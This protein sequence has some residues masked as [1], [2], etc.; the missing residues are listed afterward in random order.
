MIAEPVTGDPSAWSRGSPFD[1]PQSAT[2]TLDLGPGRWRLS[3]Q[4]HSQAPLTVRAAGSRVELPPSLDGMYLTH[5]GQ[6]AFWPAGAL[7]VRGGG[8]VT[9]TVDAARPSQLQ[10]DLGVERRVWLGTLAATRPGTRRVPLRDAC[11]LYVDHYVT[12]RR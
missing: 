1:A 7:R 11:G 12:F 10:R 2:Q 3:L 9:V 6:G 8:P 5:Q 4:Y